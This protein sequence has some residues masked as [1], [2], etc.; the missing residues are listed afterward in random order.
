M[1]VGTWLTAE[2]VRRLSSVLE[3]IYHRSRI[4]I[5]S[6]EA[7][8]TLWHSCGGP[9]DEVS[10]LVSTLIESDFILEKDGYIRLTNA[11][12]QVTKQDHQQRG[13]LLALGLIRAGYFADQVR[14]LIEVSSSEVEGGLVCDR[15]EA[16][17]IAPQLV[18][19]IRRWPEVSLGSS[20]RLAPK[21]VR[22]LTDVWPL[23]SRDAR[24]TQDPKRKVAYRAEAYSYRYERLRAQDPAKIRWIRKDDDSL[25]YDIEDASTQPQ[26]RIEVKGSRGEVVQFFMTANEWRVAHESGDEYEVHFWGRISLSRPADQEYSTLVKDGYPIVFRDFVDSIRD[27]VLSAAPYSYFVHKFVE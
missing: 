7:R 16:Q 12:R 22:A 21:L 27:G 14:R 24:S 23:L 17:R 8:L 9:L 5:L 18:G 4:G 11:G 25:G 20:L 2:R 10:Q 19:L 13:K 15:L 26:R 3:A 6:Q 1:E